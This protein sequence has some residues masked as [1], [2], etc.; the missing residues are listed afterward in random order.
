M[1]TYKVT[2]PKSGKTLRLTGDSPPTE[3]ELNEIF[4]SSEQVS[5]PQG[6]IVKQA[7]EKAKIPG[8]MVESGYKQLADLIPMPTPTGNLPMD[9]AKAGPSMLAQT[10]I[11]GTGK[12]MNDLVLHPLNALTFGAGKLAKMATPIGKGLAKAVSKTSGIDPLA[13]E[14]AASDA[15]T[16]FKPGIEK[17]NKIYGNL[18][19]S[20]P[21]GPRPAL[22]K[23]IPPSEALKV[24]SNGLL[25]MVKSPGVAGSEAAKKSRAAYLSLVKSSQGGGTVAASANKRIVDNA[26]HLAGR[27]ELS[28]KLANVARKSLDSLYGSKSVSEDFIMNAKDIL[29]AV[30]AQ[31]GNI[32]KAKE[33]RRTA[34]FVDDLRNFFPKTKTGGTGQFRTMAALAG[35]YISPALGAAMATLFSPIVQGAG[36][37]GVGLA[38]RHVN[39]IPL[40]KSQ[41]ESISR[42]LGE[43]LSKRR[44]E[45]PVK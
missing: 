40:M 1:P 19:D 35:T 9:V 13:L 20:L 21:I 27:G 44:K 32:T 45:I 6:G 4:G 11:Q 28:P 42:L 33:V 12:A 14:A 25:E 39:K 18:V 2:D 23:S 22:P 31:S 24:G 10:A 43:A 15:T 38:A 29:T 16:V 41:V 3:M 36:A 34:E 17:A 26:L 30:E 8:Q 7:W 37:A 5:Q